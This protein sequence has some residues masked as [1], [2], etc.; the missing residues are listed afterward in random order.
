MLNVLEGY[1][2]GAKGAGSAAAVHLMAETMRRAFADRARFLG[3]PDFNLDL[4]VARLTSKP[5]A[6]S[7][8]RSIR[9]D[10]ASAS[11]PERFEWP[12]ESP[13]TTHLS[14]VDAQRNAVSLTTTLEDGYGSK[15]VVPG[16]GFLLNNEMGDFNAGPGLTDATGLV[17][18]APNLAAPGKR[19]LSSMTPTILTLEGKPFLVVGSPGGRTII[20]TVLEIIV[21]VVDFG[22][23]VQDAVDFPRFHHQWL[24][25]RIQY[26]KNGLSPDTLALL[27]ARGHTLDEVDV[28]GV[29]QAIVFD[30]AQ[31][32][33]EGASD[34]RAP[35]GAAIG[36]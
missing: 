18:T 28:Q 31:D 27:R 15:I 30:A 29:A 22:L 13:Q 24:P 3:D 23:G 17:G 34:R 6:E 25:D 33:L 16:A 9:E 4:P 32:M 19:M 35:D 1:D 26:E 8:R 36:R 5:Y 7:L 12:A 20:N 21:N 2:L 10:R 14:V 11:S